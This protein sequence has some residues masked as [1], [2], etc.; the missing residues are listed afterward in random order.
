M[1]QYVLAPLATNA[2]DFDED[3]LPDAVEAVIGTQL[4]SADS[5]GDGVE[6]GAEVQQGT[7]PLDGKPARTGIIATA[8]GSRAVFDVCALNDLVAVA[9]SDRG[10]SLFNV[11]N[12]MNPTIIAQVDTPGTAS[13]VT[14][15]IGRI[16]AA[17]GQ[18][19]LAIIDITDPPA[20]QIVRQLSS[21]ELGGG[22]AQAVAAAGGLVFVGTT[23]G[24]LAVVDVNLGVVLDRRMLERPVHDLAVDGERLFVL[25]D[26]QL[27]AFSVQPLV[28]Q[29][30]GSAPL[31]GFASDGLTGRRRLSVGGGIAY[32]TAFPGYDT[33]DVSNPGVAMPRLGD[34]QD[35]G[36]NSF[37]QIA[38]NGS[39]LGVA[40]VGVNPR[41]DGTHDVYLY[42]VS[43]PAKT[44]EFLTLFE[45]PGIARAVSIYNALAYVAD[46]D[47][48]LQ[49]IN[50]LS[51]DTGKTPPTASFTTSANANGQ[52][53][54]G[55]RVLVDVTVSD[56]AQVRNVQ[57]LVDDQVVETDGNFP[58]QFFINAPLRAVQSSFTVAVRATDTG[59]NSTTTAARPLTV[60]PDMTAPTVVATAPTADAD[61][62]NVAGVVFVFDGPMDG[63]GLGPEDVTAVHFVGSGEVVPVERVELLD[64]R[65]VAVIFSDMLEPGT[66]QITIDSEATR[67]RAGNA[68]LEPAMVTFLH[69]VATIADPTPG[70]RLVQGALVRV[71]I[72]VDPPLPLR[73]ARLF[74]DGVEADADTSAPYEFE[75][76]VPA[77]ANE[78][79]LSVSVVDTD[80]NAGS[81]EEARFPVV[82][83]PLTAV[84]GRVLDQNGNP[85]VG[86]TVRCFGR[87]GVTGA[88]GSFRING[89]A[90]SQRRASPRRAPIS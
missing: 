52:V 20:A 59:G 70:Q 9:H 7:D 21:A 13:S 19:G 65:R 40:A 67:D 5:D 10:V 37:K 60:V 24:S 23:T 1:P 62:F 71:A 4:T 69:H 30:L 43:D 46:G 68:A 49:V 33:F 11:F 15:G 79:G 42:D 53:E 8:D 28:P 89:L 38:P 61:A 2:Q 72:D 83:D 76:E 22:A 25:L 58:F 80:G 12:G 39:G 34:A 50:Y 86:A 27:Q 74:I 16:V 17:D 29:L 32:A 44:A 66:Y 55:S 73:E 81:S 64:E 87:S 6:D 3:G 75:I 31:S 48:G 84:S 54:E 26:N 82:P 47:A 36:P 90:R 78:V 18:A 35:G 51:Y 45:T 77:D 14:C 57:L 56:D 85:L 63:S 88:D 41:D